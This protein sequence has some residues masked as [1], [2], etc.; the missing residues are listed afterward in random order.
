[1]VGLY[2]V[3]YKRENNLQDGLSTH[4]LS[5]CTPYPFENITLMLLGE[6]EGLSLF[7]S[8]KFIRHEL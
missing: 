2:I 8:Q 4:S 6:E 5:G 7:L 3:P 1:M